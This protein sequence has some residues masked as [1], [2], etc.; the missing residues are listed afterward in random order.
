MVP[1]MDPLTGRQAQQESF[2]EA[3]RV[4]IVDIFQAGTQAQLRLP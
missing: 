2:I 4:P 1:I 3:T